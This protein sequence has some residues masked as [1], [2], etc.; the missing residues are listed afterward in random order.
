VLEA[1]AGL[2]ENFSRSGPGRLRLSS[3]QYIIILGEIG[4][5]RYLLLK[6]IEEA[7]SWSF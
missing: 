4:M 5:N 7:L 1:P 6:F 2:F 3:G